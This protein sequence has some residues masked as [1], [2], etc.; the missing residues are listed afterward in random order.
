[1]PE[2]NKTINTC[3]TLSFSKI[4]KL[5][6][7]ELLK[8]STQIQN[9]LKTCKKN[10]NTP[11][12]YIVQSGD[13]L[14]KILGRSLF[15]NKKISIN[16]TKAIYQPNLKFNTADT[17]LITGNECSSIIKIQHIKRTIVDMIIAD[18][19]NSMKKFNGAL[20]YRAKQNIPMISSGVFTY[21][22]LLALAAKESS[23]KFNTVNG[24]CRIQKEYRPSNAM[25]N[26]YKLPNDTNLKN[27]IARDLED[28]TIHLVEYFKYFTKFKK[29]QTYTKLN[30]KIKK[31]SAKELAI[32][33]Y[34]RGITNVLKILKKNQDPR[35]YKLPATHKNYAFKIL[36]V[37]NNPKFLEIL[38]KY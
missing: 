11:K 26:K 33:A 36:N 19:A 30:D 16:N 9:D 23:L 20:L 8:C 14:S 28:A 15:Y 21:S 18:S 1:M 27:N 32:T 3:E 24:F 35:T 31:I 25:R 37:A 17:L 10:V 34:N 29:T 13:S 4:L 22:D 7:T 6:K 5:K 38:R 2:I 12:T